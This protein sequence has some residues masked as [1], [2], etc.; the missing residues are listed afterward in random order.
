MKSSRDKNAFQGKNRSCE[1]GEKPAL[2]CDLR[3]GR[4]EKKGEY[5][6]WD[7]EK[8][9][10]P[11]KEKNPNHHTPKQRSGNFRMPA[12]DDC[13]SVL[14]A[15]SSHTPCN[16]WSCP[17]SRLFGSNVVAYGQVIHSVRPD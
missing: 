12:T 9:G 5:N 14:R 2:L 1:E 8:I 11:T 4:R 17:I 13:S 16:K 3:V 15:S 7:G 6:E 10:V